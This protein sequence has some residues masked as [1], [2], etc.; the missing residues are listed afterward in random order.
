VVV[1]LVD[2]GGGMVGVVESV[3]WVNL[4]VKSFFS[5][6][7]RQSEC[8][9]MNIRDLFRPIQQRPVLYHRKAQRTRRISRVG[10]AKATLA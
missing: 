2:C 3:V 4:F 7:A 8:M 9:L 10:N 6:Q 1:V 5:L